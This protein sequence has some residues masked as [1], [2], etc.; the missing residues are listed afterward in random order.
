[1]I[2][3]LSGKETYSLR[4]K[5]E[6]ILKRGGSSSENIISYDGSAASFQLSDALS[7][8]ATVSLFD[9]HRTIIVDDPSFL[10]AGGAKGAS[11]KKKGKQKGGTAELLEQYCKNPGPDADL[12]FYC[13][14]WEPDHRLKEYTILQDAAKAH[15]CT[16]ITF[17]MPAPWELPDLVD[18]KLKER[19]YV[20]SRDAEDELLARINGS[21]SMLYLSLDKFDL[22]GKK[23]LDLT[24]IRH[25]VSPNPEADIW[26]L[27][28][29][30]ISGNMEGTFRSLQDI[31]SNGTMNEQG[32]LPILAVRIRQLYE[33]T[34]MDECGI[35]EDV[36]G[37]TLNRKRPDK[38]LMA[39]RGHGSSYFL[40][41]L[42]ELADLDQ[43]IKQGKLDAAQG[44][45]GFLL[46]HLVHG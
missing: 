13:N 15:V 35:P 36:I 4:K 12:I 17:S 7:A 33:V 31:L 9:D 14:G 42:K 40:S 43:G 5:K 25:L 11:G 6:Q 44:L 37:R 27:G 19:G 20:L 39:A 29:A 24:D 16:I 34:A 18:R 8:C 21:A 28:D 45:D 23:N 26:K 46:E 3:V 10:M 1:M 38:D 30:F 41:L 32:V 2:Y 22:Y